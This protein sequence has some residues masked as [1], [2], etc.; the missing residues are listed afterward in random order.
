[1]SNWQKLPTVS[2]LAEYLRGELKRGQ[3]SGRMPG[4]IR[5]A[6]ELGAARNTVEGALRELERD[7]LLLP[8]GHG[9]GRVIAEAASGARKTGLRVGLIPYEEADRGLSYLID[10]Q[11]RLE[12]EGH[13]VIFSQ[14]T[15]LDLQQRV[16][17]VARV[18]KQTEADAWVVMAGSREVI[19][20]FAA[21]QAPAFALFGRRREVMIAGAGPDKVSAIRNVVR[22]LAALG[23]RRIVLFVHSERRKPRPGAQ[24]RAFLE[25]LEAQGISTGAYH[26]PDWEE[27]AE[28]LLGCIDG[29]FNVTPP[30]ALIFDETFLF[31]AAQ[32]HLAQKGFLAP[33]DI[34]LVCC[35]PPGSALAWMRPSVAHIRWDH[36]PVVRRIVQWARNVS[37]GRKDLRQSQTLAE[38]VDGGTIG[39]AWER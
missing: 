22:R 12:E 30:T 7:G 16:D 25:E 10:L 6:R 33:R 1:M 17:R 2:L 19:E 35:D 29:L 5:L 28:G 23:H 20:W 32:Q 34:S 4:V 38:F 11:Y 9:R 8:Q 21:R 14:K 39:P 27:S 3:W 13:M 24:E 36:R 31:A 26:L 37:H 18:V 15:L